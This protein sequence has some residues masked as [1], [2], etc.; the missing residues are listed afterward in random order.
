M[1]RRPTLPIVLLSGLLLLGSAA[2]ARAQGL[3]AD[4]SSHLIAITTAFTGTT[5]TL[6][7]VSDQSGDIIV[8]VVGPRDEQVVR[9]KERIA[10]IWVNADQMTFANVPVFYF[11]ASSRPID[12]IA[13][14]DLQARLELGLDHLNFQPV[15]AEEASVSEIRAFED[16]LVRNKQRMQLY[17]DQVAAVRFVGAQLFRTDVRFPAN[18]PPGIYQVQVFELDGGQVTDAQRSTLV[19]SKIGLEAELFDFAHAQAPAYGMA[20][21]LI[22]L[23]AG[24][25][26]AVIFRRD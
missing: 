5:V 11:V 17:P 16:A 15:D 7:G 14:P 3:A 9:R 6:F 12:Q 4:I 8:T 10:G 26:A 18:V 23:A 20:A 13:H 24:W 19:I 21:I 1:R 25:L 22:S 2:T